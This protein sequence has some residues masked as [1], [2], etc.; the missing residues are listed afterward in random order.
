MER[1]ASTRENLRGCAV[2][3]R[4]RHDSLAVRMLPEFDVAGWGEGS[5][6]VRGGAHL[7]KLSEA[8]RPHNGCDKTTSERNRCVV[9]RMYKGRDGVVLTVRLSLVSCAKLRTLTMRSFTSEWS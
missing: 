6:C 3:A 9:V 1:N 5:I 8:E 7:G 4:D 2:A